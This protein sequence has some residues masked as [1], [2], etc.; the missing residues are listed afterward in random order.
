[1][2]Y[3][4]LSQNKQR[5]SCVKYNCRWYTIAQLIVKLKKNSKNA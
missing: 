1:M 2:K 4:K 5:V 3:S